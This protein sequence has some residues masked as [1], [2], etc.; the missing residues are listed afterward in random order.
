MTAWHL[1]SEE[2]TRVVRS[3]WVTS[4]AEEIRAKIERVANLAGLVVEGKWA[5]RRDERVEWL[6]TV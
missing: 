4:V 2:H 6:V 5:G 3:W 1:D